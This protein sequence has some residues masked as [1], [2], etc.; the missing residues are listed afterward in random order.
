MRVLIADGDPVSR[1]VLER[2]LL[3]WSYE[4]ETAHDGTAAWDVLRKPDPPCIAILDCVM[5]GMDGIEICRRV[6]A[7]HGLHLPYVILLTDKGKTA[8]IMKGLRLGAGDC[9]MRPFIREELQLRLHVGARIVEQRAELTRRV[10]KLEDVLSHIVG[11]RGQL[12]VCSGCKSVSDGNGKW[13]RFE[14]YLAQHL[15]HLFLDGVCPACNNKEERTD[16][17]RPRLGVCGSE[18]RRLMVN[19]EARSNI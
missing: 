8:D 17:E 10:R 15:E 14:T 4:V 3:D 11:F 6:C 18:E 19:S 1:Q 16:R 2:L 5:S 13:H 7:I 9:I 12:K